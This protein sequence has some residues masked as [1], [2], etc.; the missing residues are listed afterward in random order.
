MMIMGMQRPIRPP[1]TPPM[2]ME[3]FLLPTVPPK[4]FE[5]KEKEPEVKV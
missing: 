2:M 1:M 3:F 5:P 4:P